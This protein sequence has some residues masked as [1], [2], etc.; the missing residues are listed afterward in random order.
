MVDFSDRFVSCILGTGGMARICR[1]PRS[2]PWG[3]KKGVEDDGGEG[4]N[5]DD[6]FSEIVFLVD[7]FAHEKKHPGLIE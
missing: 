1:F 5:R 4:K 2:F 3:S 6:W 7:F